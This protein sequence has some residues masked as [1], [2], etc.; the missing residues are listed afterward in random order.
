MQRRGWA[1]ILCA[2]FSDRCALLHSGDRLDREPRWSVPQQT[3]RCGE[4]S[5]QSP[6]PAEKT[7][8]LWRCGSGEC[9]KN[10]NHRIFCLFMSLCLNDT[11][12]VQVLVWALSSHNIIAEVKSC[13][14]H[15]H[16]CFYWTFRH[17]ALQTSASNLPWLIPNFQKPP[18]LVMAG[19][20][21]TRFYPT[22]YGHKPFASD[23]QNTAPGFEEFCS[24]ISC[25]KQT[26]SRL[27]QVWKTWVNLVLK[28]R[29]SAVEEV[30]CFPNCR[31]QIQLEL[32][33]LLSG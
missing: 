10:I 26:C 24:A 32:W 27:G 20:T 16:V 30:V 1:V 19:S 31:F 28:C 33:R 17:F 13:H 12:T 25:R 4:I 7:W 8:R 9:Q 21:Q 6:S 2:G 14:E 22:I 15:F 5:S 18:C 3:H 29:V 23:L 11:A